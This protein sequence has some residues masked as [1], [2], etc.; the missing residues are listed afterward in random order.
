MMNEFGKSDGGGHVMFFAVNFDQQRFLLFLSISGL[1]NHPTQFRLVAF[2]LGT[3][4]NC[5]AP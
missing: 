3:D 1:M 2:V 4:E 5:R